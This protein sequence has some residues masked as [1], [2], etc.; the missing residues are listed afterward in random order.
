MFRG[1]GAPANL[2]VCFSANAQNRM[3][4]TTHEQPRKTGGLDSGVGAPHFLRAA[5]ALFICLPWF[6]EQCCSGRQRREEHKCK[7]SQLPLQASCSN[8]I[9][10]TRQYVRK[11]HHPVTMPRS[12]RVGQLGRVPRQG[13]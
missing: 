5:S 8:A 11:Q 12:A 7:E 6:K 1:T 3:A 4:L 10:L 2:V 9:S 13:H